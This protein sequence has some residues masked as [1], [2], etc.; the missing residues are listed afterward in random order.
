MKIDPRNFPL[1]AP[2]TGA[3]RGTNSRDPNGAVKSVEQASDTD[4][5]NL[6]VNLSST[7]ALRP[8]SESDIDS[9]KVESIKAALRNGTY[10]VDSGKLADGMLG[11][12]RELLRSR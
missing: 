6:T 10:T 4:A 5:Q 1:S 9:T 11:S 2:Q 7:S 3:Q 12:A 8:S